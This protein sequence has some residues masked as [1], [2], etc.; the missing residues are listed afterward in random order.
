MRSLVESYLDQDSRLSLAPSMI[1]ITGR[2]HHAWVSV[3]N[4]M[5]S[6]VSVAIKVWISEA[7][8]EL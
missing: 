1:A 6:L 5:V 2:R 4:M 7:E 3:A 8:L